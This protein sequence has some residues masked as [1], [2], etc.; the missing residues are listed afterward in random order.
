MENKK[1]LSRYSV[2]FCG[3]IISFD[4]SDCCDCEIN[5]T[6]INFMFSIEYISVVILDRSKLANTQILGSLHRTS[7]IYHVANTEITNLPCNFAL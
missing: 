1:R 6:E 7:S 2:K 5:P 4:K 3:K